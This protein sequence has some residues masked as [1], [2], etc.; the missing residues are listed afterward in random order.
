MHPNIPTATQK[1]C[2]NIAPGNKIMKEA[3]KKFDIVSGEVCPRL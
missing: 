3:N 1:I 2:Q